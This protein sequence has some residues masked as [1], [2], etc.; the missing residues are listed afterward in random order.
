V[1]EREGRN[2]DALA[3]AEQ[4]VRLTSQTGGVPGWANERVNS[5]RKKVEQDAT[6]SA[7]N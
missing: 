3:A 1:R 6:H 5:L 2:A 7:K 4:Y